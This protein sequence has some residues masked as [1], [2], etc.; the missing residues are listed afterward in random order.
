M[1]NTEAVNANDKSHI[2]ALSTIDMA[3]LESI[4]INVLYLQQNRNP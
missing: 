1:G 2:T 4:Q 3:F